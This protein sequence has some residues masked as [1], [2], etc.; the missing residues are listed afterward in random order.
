E[1]ALSR[2]KEY[3]A[4]PPLISIPKPHEMLYLYLPLSDKA[5]SAA[6]M[7]SDGGI[8]RP[9][10]YISKTLISAELNYTPLEKLVLALVTA[11]R[12]LQHYF[13][14]HPIT[15]YTSHPIKAALRRADFSGRMEKW[16]VELGRYHIEYVPR[17][18]IKGQVLADLIA[19]FE[20]V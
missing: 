14:A 20:L 5:I 2:L 18:A 17:T 9:V 1:E 15:L 4:T 10:Y 6:L 12:K 11:S 13:D 3:I 8:Q 16:S 19:E 7:R